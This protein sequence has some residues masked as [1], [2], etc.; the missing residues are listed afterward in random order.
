MLLLLYFSFYYIKFFPDILLKN[1]LI[2]LFPIYYK[3]FFF[4]K[5][6]EIN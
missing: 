5:S 6:I 1:F 3:D 4:G 2:K